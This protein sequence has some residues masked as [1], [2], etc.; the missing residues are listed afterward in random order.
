MHALNGFGH[1]GRLCSCLRAGGAE[2]VQP[3]SLEPRDAF[4]RQGIARREAVQ[5]VINSATSLPSLPPLSPLSLS[6]RTAPRCPADGLRLSRPPARSIRLLHRC[7]P[8]PGLPPLPW[9]CESPCWLLAPPAAESGV[10]EVSCHLPAG[11]RGGIGCPATPILHD[12][13]SDQMHRMCGEMRH[14]GEL[15]NDARSDK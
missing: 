1:D 14:S 10:E 2:A 15:W 5:V 11:P 8:P 9:S 4:V 12:V 13:R 3:P 6:P 7:V